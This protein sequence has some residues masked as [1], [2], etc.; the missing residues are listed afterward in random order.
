MRSTP[1]VTTSHGGIVTIDGR[2]A[3]VGPGTTDLPALVIP[4]GTFTVDY[5]LFGV[6][7][8]DATLS[9]EGGAL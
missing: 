5:A 7:A 3:T 4:G 9:W 8:P 2:M 1:S 6:F